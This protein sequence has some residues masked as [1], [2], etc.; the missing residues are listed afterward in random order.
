MELNWSEIRPIIF[1]R[2]SY[3]RSLSACIAQDIFD[4]QI[5][6]RISLIESADIYIRNSPH[7]IG[8]F[9]TIDTSLKNQL[10]AITFEATIFDQLMD[11]ILRELDIPY[12]TNDNIQVGIL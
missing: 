1:N 5:C 9:T 10:T 4:I 6:S 8:D 7:H 11:H 3:I 12:E 2:L